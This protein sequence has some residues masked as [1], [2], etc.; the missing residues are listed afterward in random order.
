M[1]VWRDAE[2]LNTLY[3]RVLRDRGWASAMGERGRRRVLAHHTYAARLA[4]LKGLI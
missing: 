3:A 4:A 2:E 1:A